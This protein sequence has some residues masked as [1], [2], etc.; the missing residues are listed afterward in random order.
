MFE[1][2]MKELT[3]IVS[4]LESGTLG[5]EESIDLF[6]KGSEL[7]KNCM[8]IIQDG[9]ET[10]KVIKQDLNGEVTEEPIDFE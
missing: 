8:K 1:E 5:I 9:K 3:E 2:Y 10:I 4:K 6:K 7:S